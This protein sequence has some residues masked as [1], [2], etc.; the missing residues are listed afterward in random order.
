MNTYLTLWFSS[1]GASPLEVKK[2]LETIGFRPVQ[3]G[4]DFVYFWQQKPNVTDLL[5]LGDSIQK[6]LTGSQTMFKME[7]V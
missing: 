3:G 7:S 2:E 1:E 4:Y 6:A 5:A